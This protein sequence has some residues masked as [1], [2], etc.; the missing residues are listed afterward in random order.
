MKVCVLWT[1][2]EHLADDTPTPTVTLTLTN[3]VLNNGADKHDTALARHFGYLDK[4]S[5]GKIST[6]S[7]GCML[8]K[9]DRRRAIGETHAAENPLYDQGNQGNQD[10]SDAESE[11]EGGALPSQMGNTEHE[12]RKVG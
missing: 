10:E 7:M 12:A 9:K 8:N 4:R 3:M 1:F 6:R 5:G 11:E 2:H